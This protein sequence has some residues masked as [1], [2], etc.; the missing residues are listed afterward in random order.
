MDWLAAPPAS[1]ISTARQKPI[2]P[3][4]RSSILALLSSLE[5]VS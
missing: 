3:G 4:L 5:Y 1:P 2:P